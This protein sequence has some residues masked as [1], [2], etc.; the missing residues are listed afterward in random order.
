M[1]VKSTSQAKD[2]LYRFDALRRLQDAQDPTNSDARWVYPYIELEP[3]GHAIREGQPCVVLIDEVDKA[4]IDFPNDLLDVL[5]RFEFD[6]E[7]LPRSE[8]EACACRPGLRPPRDRR[9][10]AACKPIVIITSNRE[11]QLP[12]PFLRRCLYV[13]LDFPAD[14]AMLADIVRKNLDAR[15]D[16]IGDELIAGAVERFCRIRE[17]GRELGMQKLPATS[18]LVDWVRVLHWQQ[19]QGRGGVVDSL[20]TVPIRPCCSSCART[21]NAIAP[22]PPTSPPSDRHP[23]TPAARAVPRA[24][25]QWRAGRHPRLPG[26]RA[27]PC[28]WASGRATGSPARSRQ[29]PVG[30]QRRGAPPHRPLVRR[31]AAP[32]RSAAAPLMT[33]STPAMPPPTKP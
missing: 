28:A 4:D 32:R 6:I 21:S 10:R 16:Q 31:A 33:N 24:A 19:P 7:D 8:D 9:P 1:T 2:L 13:Q 22:A 25:G 18:E 17:R 15:L 5:D 27:R 20:D 23:P 14:P 11:K 26:R 30:A 3:L 12:E 29:R